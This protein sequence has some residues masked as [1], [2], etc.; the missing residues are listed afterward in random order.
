MLPKIIITTF[1]FFVVVGGLSL[2]EGT[3]R[4]P[5]KFET[6]AV[7]PEARK[8][9]GTKKWEYWIATPSDAMLDRKLLQLGNQGWEMVTARRAT[10]QFGG[11]KY[12]MI[13]KRPK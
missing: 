11:A 13:F 10:S 12:E 1:A 8:S 7:S 6:V 3:L 4:P 9:W 2:F 5:A